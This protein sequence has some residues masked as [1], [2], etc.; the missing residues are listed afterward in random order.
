[1]TLARRIAACP[2]CG[3]P[4]RVRAKGISAIIHNG[5][6]LGTWMLEPQDARK[7]QQPLAY[8]LVEFCG[9]ATCEKVFR[10]VRKD[11]AESAKGKQLERAA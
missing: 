2:H 10:A 1:M 11:S 3:C 8:E 7:R 6:L 9:R 4:S 5:A